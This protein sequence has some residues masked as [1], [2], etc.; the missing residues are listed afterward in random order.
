MVKPFSQQAEENTW[1]IRG[2]L[3][4]EECTMDDTKISNMTALELTEQYSLARLSP[5][6]VTE[7]MLDRIN[8]INPKI[9]AFHHI[10]T[11]KALKS[12]REAEKR[13]KDGKPLS[14]IDGVPTAIKDGLLM[15]GIPVYRGSV[16]NAAEMQ[17]WNADA[18]V[19][20]RLEENGAVILGKTTMCDY[21]M[22]ASGY[23]SKFGPTRNPWSLDHNSGGSSSGSAAAVA[24]G[25]CPI[26]VGTDIVGSIR[27]PASF[28]GL[29][30]HKPSFGRVPFYP[31]TSPSV[32]AGPIARSVA[33]AA[34]LLTIISRPDK[35]D[36]TALPFANV[37]YEDAIKSES[38]KFKIGFMRN[39][40]FGPSPHDEVLKICEAAV[41]VFE[42][43]G[44]EIRDILP[45]FKNEDIKKAENFYRTRTLAEL[46]LLTPETRAKAEVINTWASEA[47]NYSGMDHYR[48]YLGT[49]DLRSRMFSAMEGYD[50]LLLPTVPIPPYKAENAG[51]DNGDIFAPWCN[52]FVFNLT[53]QPA[54]SVP[55]GKTSTGLPVGLQI[56][57]R[58]Q[59]DICVLR[60]AKTYEDYVGCRVTIPKM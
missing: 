42:V 4:K 13:W 50:L 52:T 12:A 3:K 43:L 33:D 1:K 37:N 35:R 20:L 40:G 18:P 16:A 25:L 5:V 51:L 28:C 60:A 22:L 57:G 2:L 26:I 36:P 17:E 32:C 47:Q 23:S 53:Q 38:T 15:K 29:Y 7:A 19:V 58:V 46:D 10:S 55:C 48:D 30:G 21:G 34:R 56:I 59:E 31:Q 6:T 54:I 14:P 49:Q 44:N 8:R 39:I 41:K 27:N 45:P 9:N 24:A 11:D